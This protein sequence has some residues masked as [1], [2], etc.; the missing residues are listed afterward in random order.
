M[1]QPVAE[2]RGGRPVKRASQRRRRLADRGMKVA[3]SLAAFV[4]IVFLVWV[5]S[6]VIVRG[7]SAL[8]WSFFTK[9]P[10]PPGASGGGLGNAMFGTLLIS[11]VATLLGVPLGVM[12]GVYLSEYGAGSRFGA[13]V[14]FM[15]N[16]MMGIPSIIAGL[17]IYTLLVVSFGHFSGYAGAVSLAFLMM[18][19]VA[20]T[21]ADMMALVPSSLREAALA[22]GAPRWG[23]TVQVVFRAA[24]AGL[25][26]GIL[27]AIARVS[28][29]TAPLLFTALN[30]P[31][32]PHGLSGPTANL[33]VTIF[34]YAMSPY[35]NWQRAAWGA[36]LV[37]TVG[38]L[39]INLLSRFLLRS[40]P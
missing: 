28:G 27:L 40:K 37:I 13:L 23:V 9:L 24:K 1:A 25:L 20:R 2:E 29:E 4:G 11:L 3:A 6:E 5:L 22:L 36:S 30:S 16:V 12:A 19:I 14:N 31:Y 8:N 33:T 15:V 34:N 26:T 39:T 21:T 35:A 32:W 38:V 17:F 18:P 10:A 7:A